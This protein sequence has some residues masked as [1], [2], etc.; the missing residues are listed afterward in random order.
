M[1]W[2]FF[3]VIGLLFVSAAF[4]NRNPGIHFVMHKQ[5]LYF[6]IF[7]TFFCLMSFIVY[8]LTKKKSV[9]A[10]LHKNSSLI[11]WGIMLAVFTFQIS[12]A[13]MIQS[14]LLHDVNLAV[15]NAQARTPDDFYWI[16][17]FSL[18]RN[19]LFLLFFSRAVF[20][21]LSLVNL[22]NSF[23]RVLILINILFIN[24]SIVLG[25]Y[26]VKSAFGV[27]K[28]YIA[29]IFMLILIVPSPWLVVPYTD[30]LSMPFAIGIV[31]FYMRFKEAIKGQKVILAIVIG[32]TAQL[33]FLFKPSAVIP[34][35]AVFIIQLIADL[36]LLKQI[37]P[38]QCTTQNKTIKAG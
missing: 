8:L 29:W 28:A 27:Y 30:T 24:A 31:Y 15:T 26:A 22:E 4:F 33:G 5:I 9:G 23:E 38:I 2:L 1:Q 12:C 11:V 20:S 34:L 6:M 37:N 14:E 17:Y 19:N 18:F 10:F 32:V 3:A 36:R 13:Y 25:F 21:I 7:L 35:I 16:E